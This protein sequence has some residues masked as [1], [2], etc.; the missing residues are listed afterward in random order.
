MATQSKINGRICY[1][2]VGN[3]S[4]SGTMITL[5][6][7]SAK[8]DGAGIY[9]FY[10]DGVYVQ[11]VGSTSTGFTAYTVNGWFQKGRS[12]M[13]MHEAYAEITLV[14]DTQNVQGLAPTAG[15]TVR[16]AP[17]YLLN[18]S[19]EERPIE[20]HPRFRCFWSYNLYELVVIGGTPSAVPAWAQTDSNPAAIHDGYL[21]SHIPPMSQDPA[22]EY[23]QAQAATKFGVNSYLIPRPVV[24]ATVYYKTRD[25]GT[26]DLS[27]VGMLK[28]PAEVYI[29]G[30][31]ASQWLVT[32]SNVQQASDDLMDV[33]TTYMY[34]PEGW[35]TDIYDVAT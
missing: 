8:A 11:S 26:S 5:K 25:V 32:A 23:V 34:V 12:G 17:V 10:A 22:K 1:A 27:V 20:Q 21:W 9:N 31:S 3:M 29:Y 35:D 4:R 18:T 19:A 33:T 7:Y 16:Y 2:T 14:F 28:A 13:Q 24:T 30:S 6:F 15:S